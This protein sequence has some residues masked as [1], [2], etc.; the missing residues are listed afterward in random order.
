MT[1]LTK[2]GQTSVIY[3]AIADTESYLY[4]MFLYCSYPFLTKTIYPMLNL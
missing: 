4:S 2:L 3:K 1:F